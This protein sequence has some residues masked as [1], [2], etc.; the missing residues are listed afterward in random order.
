MNELRAS[1][2]PPSQARPSPGLRKVP[3]GNAGRGRGSTLEAE[4]LLDLLP[5]REDEEKGYEEKDAEQDD[6]PDARTLQF[7]RMLDARA[8]ARAGIRERTR[9][10]RGIDGRIV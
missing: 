10:R 1:T 2:S 7:A 5:D 4:G 8:A 3:G 9:D 6:E